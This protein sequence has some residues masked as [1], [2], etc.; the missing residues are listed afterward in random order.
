MK[1]AKN[2]FRIALLITLVAAFSRALRCG[3]EDDRKGYEHRGTGDQKLSGHSG[4]FDEN[5]E[6]I[7]GGFAN[8]RS[9]WNVATQ[10]FKDAHFATFP[11]ALIRPCI[12][13]GSR[14]GGIIYDPFFGSGTTGV[15]AY[16][17][18]RKFIGSE[19]NPEYVEIANRRLE[20]L[21]AQGGLFT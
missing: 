11:E 18:G 19:L 2:I 5:G 15:V 14:P 8:K 9:V 16:K 21:L 10:S 20:P 4:N 1:T 3:D 7:G 12:L 6:L 17:L 13:A